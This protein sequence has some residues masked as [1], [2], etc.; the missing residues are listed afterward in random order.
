MN[1]Q[2]SRPLRL[3][4][5]AFAAAAVLVAAI[6]GLVTFLPGDGARPVR[7]P[8]GL[9]CVSIIGFF[10]VRWHSLRKQVFSGQLLP[11]GFRKDP[12]RYILGPRLPL[13][14]WFAITITLLIGTV[15]LLAVT[16]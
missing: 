5:G 9:F 2:D 4:W 6:I 10:A 11:S 12:R 15:V 8:M 13:G 7:V 16:Q 3:G 1:N 14:I